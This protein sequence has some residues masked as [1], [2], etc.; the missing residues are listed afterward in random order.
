MG[1]DN[2]QGV[3][4]VEGQGTWGGS[5]NAEVQAMIIEGYWHPGETAKEKPEVAKLNRRH[6]GAGASLP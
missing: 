1:A 4:S 5:Y 3:R 2:L 6:V